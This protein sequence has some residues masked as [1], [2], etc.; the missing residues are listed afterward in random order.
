MSVRL[1]LLIVIFGFLSFF[2]VLFSMFSMKI[3]GVKLFYDYTS[4]TVL[5]YFFHILWIKYEMSQNRV[6]SVI[7]E[8]N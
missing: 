7:V 6:T 1:K 3:N 2:V 8:Q 5:R 4:Y